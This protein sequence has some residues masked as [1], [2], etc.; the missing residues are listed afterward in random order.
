[1]VGCAPPL[2]FVNIS[3]SLNLCISSVHVSVDT[4]NSLQGFFSEVVQQQQVNEIES[5]SSE[6]QYTNLRVFD[7]GAVDER[8]VWGTF[9][10]YFSSRLILAKKPCF[11]AHPFRKRF[12]QS[13]KCQFWDR[14]L[15][16]NEYDIH[17][18]YIYLSK[19]RQ[20]KKIHFLIKKRRGSILI[21]VG[22]QMTYFLILKINNF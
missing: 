7:I 3:L 4:S 5:Q 19:G 17:D 14:S 9:R 8:V 12:Q 13:N 21:F 2:F 22:I 15:F 20:E 11:S 18:S 1:M 10:P 16:K 6:R